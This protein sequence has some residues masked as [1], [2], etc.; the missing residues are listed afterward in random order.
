MHCASCGQ[1]CDSKAKPIGRG[2]FV[3]KHCQTYR[4]EQTEAD[5]IITFVKQQYAKA[6]ISIGAKWHLKMITAEALF[7]K[8]KDKNTRGLAQMVG[9]EYTIFIYREL[10]RV[11]FAQ[12]L[13]HEMLHIYQY[14]RHINP[15]KARCEGF[16]NLGSYVILTAIGNDEAK[17]AIEN[18]KASTDSIYGDGFREMLTIYQ[19]AGWQG[20]IKEVSIR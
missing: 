5:N 6:G 9:T 11:A 12:V 20:A 10:S 17:A 16:C 3:C 15:D 1:F 18:L 14:V 19:H 7:Q 13:A 2:E 8:T 4:I